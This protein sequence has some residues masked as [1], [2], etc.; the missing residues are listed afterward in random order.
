MAALLNPLS[1][2]SWRRHALAWA[3]AHWCFSSMRCIRFF[4]IEEPDA[5]TVE[6]I[7]SPSQ[8]MTRAIAAL[9]DRG[10]EWRD[11][12]MAGARQ[13]CE[14]RSAELLDLSDAEMWEVREAGGADFEAVM[15]QLQYNAGY[16]L[17]D[18][19]SFE[20]DD[21]RNLP[22]PGIGLRKLAEALNFR[23]RHGHLD[24]QSDRN[25]NPFIEEGQARARARDTVEHAPTCPVHDLTGQ[26]PKTLMDAVRACVPS[27]SDVFFLSDADASDE[28]MFILFRRRLSSEPPDDAPDIYRIVGSFRVPSEWA[29]RMAQAFLGTKGEGGLP[30]LRMWVMV[31]AGRDDLESAISR[32]LSHAVDL[33]GAEVR[34]PPVPPEQLALYWRDDWIRIHDLPDVEVAWAG[35]ALA[36]SGER[37]QAKRL[38]IRFARSPARFPGYIISAK[39]PLAGDTIEAF[40]Q[41][42]I[43]AGSLSALQL[44]EG[45]GD[46]SPRLGALLGRLGG[47]GP[48]LI[49]V[50]KPTARTLL[51]ALMAALTQ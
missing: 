40:E 26:S 50:L 27:S 46:V 32:C 45:P 12:A 39:T 15:T 33:S 34:G 38:A 21:W 18:N 13:T 1:D 41:R 20:S 47:L 31:S 5:G 9:Q 4:A 49:H 2:R 44:P 14:P 28:H 25:A 42:K 6:Q 35:V 36:E 43:S 30:N 8:R 22:E 19:L 3:F 37:D 24:A 17:L 29:L 48:L 7:A 10:D 23:V 16:W 11:A 51:N